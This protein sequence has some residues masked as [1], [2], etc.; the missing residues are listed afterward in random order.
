MGVIDDYPAV[1]PGPSQV[2]LTPSYR[3][4]LRCETCYLFGKDGLGLVQF[5]E[6]RLDRR[7]ELL[8]MLAPYSPALT[9]V[10][11][12]SLMD[13]PS[14]RLL[15]MAVELGFEV[16]VCTNGTTLAAFAPAVV[17]AGVAVLRV[18]LD[19]PQD[20]HDAVRGA[21]IF[22]SVERGVKAV[23]AARGAAARP[24]IVLA[25][26]ISEF[27]LGR[28][29]EVADLAVEWGVDGV[30][31]QHL[32]FSSRERAADHQRVFGEFTGSSSRMM[33][34]FE[35]LFANPV[36]LDRLVD[37]LESLLARDDIAVSL[38]P[39][40]GDVRAYYQSL[41]HTFPSE[42]CSFPWRGFRVLPDGGVSPC[43]AHP[44]Y[45]VGNL[46]DEG[47]DGV[48]RGERMQAFRDQLETGG[49]FPGCA[50]CCERDYGACEGS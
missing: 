3:C 23:V 41:D 27:S 17:E 9:V 39:E 32:M 24:R 50:R 15:E 33:T 5:K 44:D 28:L 43:F 31:V 35:N 1:P 48:W 29:H 21:G 8:E 42:R 25:P 4:N 11:G 20:V 22:K 14:T 10:G 30:V 7:R 45:S 47:L 19:G 46:L 26:L 38:T 12:E 16:T 18:S 6:L 40:V 34:G 37:E 49:L 36:D 2:I 13:R